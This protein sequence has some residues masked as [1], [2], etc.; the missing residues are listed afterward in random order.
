VGVRISRFAEGRPA[1]SA[2]SGNRDIVV[3]MTG[4][5]NDDGNDN[6]D[7]LVGGAPGETLALRER[8]W[9]SP[10]INPCGVEWWG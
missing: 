9:G 2:E 10:A 8:G 3:V 4:Q 1:E 6:C 5:T 7:I